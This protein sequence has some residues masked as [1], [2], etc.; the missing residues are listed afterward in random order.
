MK[1]YLDK[2][3]EDPKVKGVALITK[4]GLIIEKAFYDS[5][6]SDIVGAM[7]AKIILEMEN[8]LGKASN[9]LPI[10]STLYAEEGEIVLI[11][12]EKFILSVLAEK[13]ANIGVLLI[14]LRNAADQIQK[15]I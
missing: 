10:L 8:A 4:D 13:N 7:V 1:Q 11:A 9:E 12:K 14:H 5:Q 6:S 2:L 3:N 15:E